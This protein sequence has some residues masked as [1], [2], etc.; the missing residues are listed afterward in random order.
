MHVLSEESLSSL[1]GDYGKLLVRFVG[2]IK[3]LP[4]IELLDLRAVIG[5]NKFKI[6]PSQNLLFC[7]PED[8]SGGWVAKNEVALL[9]SLVDHVTSSLDYLPE[10]CFAS[11]QQLLGL[12]TSV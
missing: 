3:N 7:I 8:L 4:M 2:A 12:P 9:I 1:F 5:L 6:V 11:A 10:R